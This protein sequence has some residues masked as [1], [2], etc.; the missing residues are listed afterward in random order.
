M[1]F[2]DLPHPEERSQ[3]ASRRTHTGL[4]REDRPNHLLRGFYHPTLGIDVGGGRRVAIATVE[5]IIADR[6]GQYA[7]TPNHAPDISARR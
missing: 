2:T 4:Q 3:S 1:A 7:S 6:M 5:D